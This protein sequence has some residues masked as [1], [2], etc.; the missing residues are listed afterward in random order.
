[1][2]LMI[3]LVMTAVSVAFMED[4]TDINFGILL[5]MVWIHYYYYFFFFYSSVKWIFNG[6]EG[7]LNVFLFFLKK[8]LIT[9]PEGE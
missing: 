9:N 3:L 2:S 4:N 5:G 8:F 7:I 6:C 1:M